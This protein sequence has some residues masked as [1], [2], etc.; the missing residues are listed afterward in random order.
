MKRNGILFT[1]K[2]TIIFT[3]LAAFLLSGC[4]EIPDQEWTSLIYPDKTN[5]KRNKKN[6][7][8]PTL[9]E[10]KKAS[11]LELT[12]LGFQDRGDY[13]CGLNCS[14]HEGMKVDICEEMSK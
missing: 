1:G 13:Q 5:N 9:E 4:G 7:I 14:Y 2:K 3:I 11:I 10:C 6:G 12:N 8:Y